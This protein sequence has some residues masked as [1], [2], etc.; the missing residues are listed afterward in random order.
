MIRR[1]LAAAAAFGLA[2]TPLAAQ[3]GTEYPPMPAAGT[4]KP[5]AVPASETY[6]LANGMQVTL[7]P[8]GLVPKA[9][10]NLRVYAGSLNE[11]EDVGLAALSGQMLREGAGGR[12]GGDLAAAAA[13]M[14]ANLNVGAGTHET[15]FG[16]NVLSEHADDAVR[17]IA[18]LGRRPDL[19]TSEFERVRQ[20]Y[21]RNVAVGK[22]QPQSAAD[23]AL[24]AAY[25]GPNH[26]Y[27]RLFP[28]DS[29]LAAYS[30]DDVRRY[31][32][33]NFGAKRA[34]LFVA[35]RFDKA[36]VKAAIE[37]AF[38]GWAAG[39]ERLRL[40]PSPQSG[41]KVIL[42]DRPGAPQSTLRL[43]FPAP[44]AGA[45]EDIGFRV[46][47]ALLG[48]SFTSR[49]TANIREQKGYTYSPSSSQSYNPGEAQWGFDA[50][51]TTDVTGA[52][53]KEVFGEI[54]RLQT[55]AVPDEEAAG[56]RTWMAG[57]FV[58]Q[59]ASAAGLIGSVAERD[60]HGLPADWLTAYVP[61]VLKVSGA[62]M[63]RLAGRT[64]PL[65]KMILVVVGDLAKVEPQLKA[66]PELRG[67]TFQ[68]VTPF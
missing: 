49:I 47:N 37:Q 5:F 53:L 1:L 24:A 68:R 52:A 45:P 43:A 25:Y 10:V 31:Y 29:K 30:A 14:G 2:A 44:V 20:A 23:A 27:G 7:I 32:R 11:G 65:E 26:P 61:N 50:D 42:V 64:L 66:I 28:A 63:Q 19:P 56:M 16:L 13:A 36:A 34:R 62:D 46:T 41:P 58:L 48:G 12:S 21:A 18:D 38:G 6:R 51:V 39:P 35:G 22:S 15:F 67:M 59:N 3:P 8:Y 33:A 54:R 57:T 4:P 17:L 40:P 60:F 9:V 55:E